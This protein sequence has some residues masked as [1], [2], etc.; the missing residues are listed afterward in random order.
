M[1]SVP[2][3]ASTAVRPLLVGTPPPGRVVGVHPTSVYVE[4]GAEMVALETA[5]GLGL[6]CAVRLGAD[7]TAAPFRGVRPGDVA[8]VGQGRVRVGRLVVPV[9]RWWAPRRPRPGHAY[10]RIEGLA[11]LLADRPCPV[12]ASLPVA[13]L[14][15]RG[16][17]LTPA[18][19]D[20][21]A[22][23][24]IGLHHHPDLRDPVTAEVLPLAGGTSALAGALLRSAAAGQHIPAVIDV[25]DGLAGHR[26]DEGFET[27]LRR[28]LA[29][30]HSSGTALAHG[31]LR[32]ARSVARRHRV[33]AA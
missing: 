25:A 30:G 31:L 16:P 15:G 18:G 33:A 17:G 12:H 20:V 32:G 19:D 21:V 1:H 5:D 6:P 22:G 2:G 26:T 4:T 9:V 28:L 10:G 13:E 8:V 29:V 14:I 23:L 11:R 7:R 24:L 3:A 27:A